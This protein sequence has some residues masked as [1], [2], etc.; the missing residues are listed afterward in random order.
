M[1]ACPNGCAHVMEEG[2]I[3]KVFQREDGEYVL[4][5][6]ILVY[7]CPNCN[8]QRVPD[9]SVKLI[10]DVLYGRVPATKVVSTALYDGVA[11]ET[12]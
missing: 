4:I 7:T 5:T 1:K 10:E 6:N 8:E 12:S 9:A 11:L 3:D 2:R